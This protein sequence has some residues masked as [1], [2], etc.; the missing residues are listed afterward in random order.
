M[1]NIKAYLLFTNHNKGS[2]TFVDSVVYLKKIL[3]HMHLC[4]ALQL[5]AGMKM[6]LII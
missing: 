3:D 4:S 1:V 2:P 5:D 6:K